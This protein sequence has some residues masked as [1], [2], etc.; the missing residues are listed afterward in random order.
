[1][2]FRKKE[3][4][5]LIIGGSRF[6]GPRIIDQLLLKDCSVTV[7]NRGI[8]TH[9]YPSGVLFVRGDRQQ[10]FPFKEKFDAVV[11]MCA[12]SGSDSKRALRDLRFDFFVHMGTAAAYCKSDIFPLSEDSSLG[13]W[14]LW[15][16]YN[17]GKVECE[18]VLKKGGVR[19]AVVRPVYVLG[20]GS[21]SNR[22]RFI[23]QKIKNGEPLILPGDGNALV[24]Y[25]FVEEVVETVSRILETRTAGP[26]NCAGN[27]YITL[28]GLVW[29][30][31]GLVGKKPIIRFNLAADGVN[32]NPE[33]FPFANEHLI[34]TNERARSLGVRFMPL[35]DGLRRD[36]EGY[37]KKMRE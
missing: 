18:K 27:D 1:M 20:A 24:Q 36:Y 2:R 7:F 30:M 35:L 29:Q 13:D 4:S 17:R 32:H 21:H 22:E 14:P 37:Y 10:G 11:D 25:V 34:V 33:E 8:L 9:V 28:T 12:Y 3:R 6:I 5:V 19:F 15:G 31:A 16:T 23:Y 26:V